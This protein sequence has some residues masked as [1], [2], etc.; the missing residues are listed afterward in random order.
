MK[1]EILGLSIAEGLVV[2]AGVA[3]PSGLSKSFS[4]AFSS[5]NSKVIDLAAEGIDG[6]YINVDVFDSN[7]IKLDD[8][9]TMTATEDDLTIET[10]S[11]IT[12]TFLVV[13]SQSQGV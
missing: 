2:T 11:N 10:D 8:G 4:V 9:L 1:G 12:E 13:V 6:R 7:G 5:E 3:A